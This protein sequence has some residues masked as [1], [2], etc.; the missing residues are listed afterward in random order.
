MSRL[1]PKRRKI[2]F[3]DQLRNISSPVLIDF[4]DFLDELGTP[5]TTKGVLQN[6]Q[7]DSKQFLDSLTESDIDDLEKILESKNKIIITLL[8]NLFELEGCRS[9]LIKN[10][11]DIINH[12]LKNIKHYIK[13]K[14]FIPFKKVIQSSSPVPVRP[15]PTV[16]PSPPVPPPRF[17]TSPIFI[18]D[19]PIRPVS[20]IN[21]FEKIMDELISNRL[22]QNNVNKFLDSLSQTDIPLLNEMMLKMNFKTL[23]SL[24]NIFGMNN[25]NKSTKREMIHHLIENFEYYIQFKQ[26]E[27]LPDLSLEPIPDISFPL[28]DLDQILPLDF[29]EDIYFDE[30][31]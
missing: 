11:T 6:I 7:F 31:P 5:Q 3:T 18:P 9:T 15:S 10:K 12:V 2:M 26:M 22:N 4:N 24:C 14:R 25:C 8:C 28:E 30:L 19:L 20:T 21:L 29:P 16:R 17:S 27:P 23:V 13:Y 1:T